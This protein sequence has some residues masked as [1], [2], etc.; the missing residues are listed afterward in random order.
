MQRALTEGRV[1]LDAALGG[2]ER[3]RHWTARCWS[4]KMVIL[5]HN[6]ERGG[7]GGGGGGWERHLVNQRVQ[8]GPDGGGAEAVQKHS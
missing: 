3:R 5:L 6:E 2:E 4:W 8:I 1:V 7:D